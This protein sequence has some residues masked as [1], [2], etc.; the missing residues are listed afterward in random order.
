MCI[1]DRFITGG[2]LLSLEPYGNEEKKSFK[3]KKS[4]TFLIESPSF[5]DYYNETQYN[6]IKNYV[7]SVEDAIYGKNF[8]NEKGV[9]YSD[10]MDVAST[11]YYYLIQEFSMNGD[12]YASTST[13]SVSY[14]HLDVYKR[15]QQLLKIITQLIQNFHSIW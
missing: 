1:R 6:Y 15:Q 7:Q 11:V 10:L 5:E 14:T 9:S 13:Y 4:N 8:K 3:T 2:Y 12:G